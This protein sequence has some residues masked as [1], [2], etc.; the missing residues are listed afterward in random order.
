VTDDRLKPV[1]PPVYRAARSIPSA[2]SPREELLAIATDAPEGT[3]LWRDDGGR[4]RLALLLDSEGDFEDSAAVAIVAAVALGDAIGGLA[5][6][7]VAVNNRWPDRIEVNGGLSAGITLDQ[8]DVSTAQ[9]RLVLG[10][11]VAID[12]ETGEEPGRRPDLTSLVQEGCGEITPVMLLESFARHFLAWLHRWQEDG[13][14]PVRAAWSARGP[15]PGARFALTVGDAVVEG[16]FRGIGAEGELILERDGTE[17]RMPLAKPLSAG[18]S[19]SL[20]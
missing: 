5:P 17:I 10:I 20:A 18:P 4:L 2:G 1:L 7:V 11:E 15:Q 14:P 12:P 9:L 3:L 16:S 13:F 8:I 6:P 19:W